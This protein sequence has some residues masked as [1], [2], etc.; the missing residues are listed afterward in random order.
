MLK[1]DLTTSYPRSAREKLD[2]VVQV[3]RAI[4]KGIAA[5]NG[6]NGE[7]NFDC[8]MDRGVFGFLGVDGNDVLAVIKKAASEAEVDAYFKPFIAKKSGAEIAAFNE[9]FLAGGPHDPGSQAYFDELRNAAAPDRTDVTTWVDLLDLD[10]KRPVPQRV[11][12]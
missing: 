4:D 9:Q 12:A 1:K 8:P 5:A 11:P 3:P 2:G 6:T 10:E 7:Y